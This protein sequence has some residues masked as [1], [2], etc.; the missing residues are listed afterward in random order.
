MVIALPSRVMSY[1]VSAVSPTEE[2]ITIGQILSEVAELGQ[3]KV[4]RVPEWINV[5][6][7]QLN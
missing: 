2:L 7:N 6:S 5:K 4:I 3:R 1:K